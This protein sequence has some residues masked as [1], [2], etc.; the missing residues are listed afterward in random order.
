MTS[1]LKVDDVMQSPVKALPADMLAVD[2]LQFAERCH[3]H[4]FPLLDHGDIVGMVCTCDLQDLKLK[5]PIRSAMSHGLATVPAHWGI[6][7][8]VL[9][10]SQQAVGS[11]IVVDHGAIVGIVTREDLARAGA[12]VQNMPHFR[13]RS[14]GSIHHLK[15]EGD[16]GTLCIDCRE[17]ASPEVPGDGTGV[18]D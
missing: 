1:T 10:M 8:A 6:D 13:C 5:A 15:V 16:K 9:S 7:Q 14:C 18:G 11:L 12:D 17:R 4:H 3:L 2:A